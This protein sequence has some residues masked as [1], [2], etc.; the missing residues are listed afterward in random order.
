MKI[1]SRFCGAP[2]SDAVTSVAATRKPNCRRLCATSKNPSLRWLDTFSRKHHRGSHS[3]MILSKWGHKCR[4]SP[5][6]RFCPATEKGWQGYPPTIPSTIPCSGVE[7]KV[8]TQSQ[9][10]TAGMACS[11]ILATR[12]A[13]ACTSRSTYTKGCKATPAISRPSSSPPY[14]VHRETILWGRIAMSP[15]S[16]HLMNFKIFRLHQLDELRQHAIG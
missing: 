14:P 10:G 15:I 9:I 16:P 4:G 7:S 2:T 13:A 1:R 5:A 11:S 6:P 3:R 8:S 12:L